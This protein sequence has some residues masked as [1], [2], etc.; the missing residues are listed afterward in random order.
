MGAETE[1]NKDPRTPKGTTIIQEWEIISFPAPQSN[2]ITKKKP[3][4]TQKPVSRKE[5]QTLTKI[6]RK[7]DKWAKILLLTTR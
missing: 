3:H 2:F 7:T 1:N 6:P 5:S 4:K